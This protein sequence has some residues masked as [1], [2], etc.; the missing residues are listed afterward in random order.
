MVINVVDLIQDHAHVVIHDQDLVIVDI[1]INQDREVVHVLVVEV[2]IDV[3]I[4]EDVIIDQEQEQERDQDQDRDVV[5][6][7]HAQEHVVDQD[8]DQEIID[9]V[10]HIQMYLVMILLGKH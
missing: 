8:H 9:T 2:E 1:V 6:I 7:E 5:I 4:D 3:I 10:N